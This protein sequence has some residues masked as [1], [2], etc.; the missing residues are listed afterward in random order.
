MSALTVTQTFLDRLGLPYRAVG[1]F[2]FEAEVECNND[3]AACLFMLAGNDLEV[4]FML[5]FYTFVT[6]ELCAS[7]ANVNH[8]LPMGQ[9]VAC[10]QLN[11]V[12]ANLGVPTGKNMSPEMVQL[13]YEVTK[14]LVE[15]WAEK[16]WDAAL[17]ALENEDA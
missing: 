5:P 12:S 4:A 11:V 2:A 3:P 9:F 15:A 8:Q 7:L 10:E 14:D 1:D 13:A 16:V 6:D 17:T